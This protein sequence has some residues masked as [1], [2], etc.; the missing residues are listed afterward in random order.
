MKLTAKYLRLRHNKFFTREDWCCFKLSTCS[1]KHPDWVVAA[2]NLQ[3]YVK[4]NNVWQYFKWQWMNILNA[5]ILHISA[6]NM[7]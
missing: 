5:V 1:P 7:A 2:K 6:V 4:I 3:K